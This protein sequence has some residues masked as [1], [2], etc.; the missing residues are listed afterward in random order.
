MTIK[1]YLFL[2][3]SATSFAAC[4]S[5]TATKNPNTSEKAAVSRNV[6]SQKVKGIKGPSS[7]KSPASSTTQI[8]PNLPTTTA[9]IPPT[10]SR[11]SSPAP[12]PSGLEY[13]PGPQ[14]TYS[15]QPQPPPHSCHYTF[16]GTDPLPDPHCTPGALNPRVTQG[17]IDSTICKSAIHPLLGRRRAL[18]SQKKGLRR[19]RI[20]TWDLFGLPS[21][22]IW[23][24]WN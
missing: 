2:A 1:G 9:A 23:Y 18:P 19:K 11:P 14:A 5:T 3:L 16:I 4:G 21:T 24:L 8:A 12:R 20:V 7:Y 6:T 22:T 10:T 17:V 13:G 15:V